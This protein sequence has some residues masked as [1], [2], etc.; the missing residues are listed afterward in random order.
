MYR[1]QTQTFLSSDI[2]Q[3]ATHNQMETPKWYGVRTIY[4][5]ENRARGRNRL[6]EERIVLIQANS[7]E[8]ALAKAETE[9]GSYGTDGARDLGHTISFELFDAP[10]EGVEVFCLMRQ[11][12]LEPKRYIEKFFETGRERTS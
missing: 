9:A 12:R 8:E 1:K 2:K 7:H 3:P 11:S 5:H 10:R 4:E 6:Y